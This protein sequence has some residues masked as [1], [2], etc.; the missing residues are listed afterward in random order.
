MQKKLATNALCN[1]AGVET[2]ACVEGIDMKHGKPTTTAAEPRGLTPAW[3]PN[4]HSKQSL[5]RGQAGEREL[6][7]YPC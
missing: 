5:R 6:P 2:T 4:R 1:S 7:G 3:T